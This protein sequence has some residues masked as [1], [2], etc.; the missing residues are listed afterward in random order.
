M[1]Q[2]AKQTANTRMQPMG[3]KQNL[4][5]LLSR[6]WPQMQKVMS[7][8]MSPQRV[9]QMYV[10]TINRNPE[11]ADCSVESVL[12]CFLTASSLGLEPSDVNKLGMLY[13]LPYGNKNMRTGQKEATLI[14]GY[15]GMIELARRSGE[16]KSISARTVHEGDD[17]R[18]KYGLNEDLHHVPCAQPGELTHAYM[19]AQFKDGGHYFLVMSKAEIDEVKRRSPSANSSKSPWRSD[20]EAMARKTVI[21]RSFPY[22]PVSVEARRAA[23]VD[24]GT[25]DYMDIFHPVIEQSDHTVH[26]ELVDDDGVIVDTV[27]TVDEVTPGGS[28]NGDVLKGKRDR[29]RDYLQS[30]GFTSEKE[31]MSAI[32]ELIHRDVPG[33]DDMS[34]AELDVMLATIPGEE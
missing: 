15:K 16:I 19:I 14:I 30:T 26:D 25:P 1:G 11:L 5:S 23:A 7:K 12:G 3:N 34:E 29:L 22:L 6:A 24:D 33:I 32:G 31:A 8:E 28:P 10:S 17:F 2:L 13:I 20:Y 9:Y 4:K 18:Y 21:R 27:Q